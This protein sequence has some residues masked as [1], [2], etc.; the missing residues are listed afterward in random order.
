MDLA[1]QADLAARLL[2]AALLGAVIGGERDLHRHPAGTR[3]QLL[4]AVGCA[5]FTE[6][7]IYGFL[8]A[9]AGT[10][11]VEPSRIASNI[12]T[13]IGFLGAGSI[14]KYGTSIRGLTTAASLW[15]TAAVGVAAGA[16]EWLL[17]LIGSAI[18]LLSLWPLASVSGWIRGRH[19]EDVR[20]SVVVSRLD[21]LPEIARTVQDRGVSVA[22][23][24]TQPRDDRYDLQLRLRL[25][26]GV[27]RETVA[28]AVQA[29]PG[30][31]L[32]QTDSAPE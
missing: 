24:Q 27:A 1:L 7:S 15:S 9:P 21:A 10:A 19:P 22:S 17:A 6:M 2:F 5:L 12:V 13:G 16:G 11:P 23:I 25:P 28:A 14:L 31:E 3:T 32:L 8:G 29:V 30:V 18:V 4:V 26:A 20:F